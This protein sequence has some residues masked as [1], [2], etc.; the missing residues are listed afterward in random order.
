MRMQYDESTSC[1]RP[2]SRKRAGVASELR[3]LA[4]YKNVALIGAFLGLGLGFALRHRAPERSSFDRYYFPLLAVTVL[5]VLLLGR[6]PL[7]E[8][9][10][11]NRTNAQEF[12]WAGAIG[13]DNPSVTTLLDVAF[14][15]LLLFL[16]ALITLLFIPLGNLTAHKFAAFRPLPGYTI[17][18]LGSLIGILSYTLISFLGWPP[19]VWFLLAGLA[20]LYFLPRTGTRRWGFKV[21]WL[22]YQSY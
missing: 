22:P 17:N 9:I 8:L 21:R 15:A 18:I 5:I 2:V 13:T 3:V 14:Y 12:V 19:V 10:L 20:G 6:T 11:L 4:F 16:F 1:V 7:S